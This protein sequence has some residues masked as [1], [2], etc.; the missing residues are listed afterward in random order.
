MRRIA[1]AKLQKATAWVEQ[2]FQDRV[3]PGRGPD[4]RPLY[5]LAQRHVVQGVEQETAVNIVAFARLVASEVPEFDT[6]TPADVKAEL[7]SITREKGY[8]DLE[9]LLADST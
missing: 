2:H 1:K 6:M 5:L 9:R 7:R 3:L 4:G 8:V